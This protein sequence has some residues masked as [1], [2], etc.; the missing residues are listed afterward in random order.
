MLSRTLRS[1]DCQRTLSY[2]RPMRTRW[3]PL[4]EADETFFA[5]APGHLSATLQIPRTAREVWTDLTADAPLTWCRILD[6]VAWTS[7]RPFGVGTTRTV[8]S[9]RGANVLEERFFCWDDGRRQSFFVERA[10]GPGFRRLAEDYIVRPTGSD[11]CELTWTVAFELQ[12]VARPARPL[13]ER[14][15]ATV[16]ADTR[17]YYDAH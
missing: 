4:Q 1:T 15:L 12:A 5:A 10:S 7:P 8:R 17:A 16:F 11:M 6:S 14:L 2:G 13:V 9:L 3:F